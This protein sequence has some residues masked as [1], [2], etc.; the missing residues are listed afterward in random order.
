MEGLAAVLIHTIG[1]STRSVGHFI[2][3]LN[4]HAVEMIADVRTVPRPRFNPHFNRDALWAKSFREE[5]S[6]SSGPNG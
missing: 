4:D 2:G 3:L 1:H 5:Y 6:R